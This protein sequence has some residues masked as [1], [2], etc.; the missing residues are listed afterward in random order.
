MLEPNK[1]RLFD[2]LCPENILSYEAGS[3]RDRFRDVATAY[4]V[5][6]ETAFTLTRVLISDAIAA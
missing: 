6:I 2:I 3:S 1:A 4:V 5:S